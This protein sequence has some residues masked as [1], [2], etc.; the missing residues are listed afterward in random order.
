MVFQLQN[1]IRM[2]LNLMH[3]YYVEL[4]GS[5]FQYSPNIKLSEIIYYD[6]ETTGLN[7]ITTKLLNMHFWNTDSD[8]Y[9]TDLV[10][11]ECKF[12]KKITD[13]TGIYPDDL[14]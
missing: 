3:Q 7:H 14:K 11:P 9:I 1:S 10:D 13:I 6:F 5:I 4:R 8:D 2:F 12:A